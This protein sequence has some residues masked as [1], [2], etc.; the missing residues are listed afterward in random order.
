MS[1]SDPIADLLTRIRNAVMA[2][3]SQ[4]TVPH[5]KLKWAIVGVLK[6]EGFVERVEVLKDQPRPMIRIWLKYDEDKKP[7]L[8]GIRRISKP[9][10]GSIVGEMTS[11]G[12]SAAWVWRSCRLPGEWLLMPRRVA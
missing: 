2:R 11:L 5:S 8:T 1:M 4:V 6:E 12:S 3:H 7:V 9:G 10:A